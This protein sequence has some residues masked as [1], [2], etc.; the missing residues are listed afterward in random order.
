M[1]SHDYTIHVHTTKALFSQLFFSIPWARICLVRWARSHITVLI[2]NINNKYVWVVFHLLNSPFKKQLKILMCL[3]LPFFV[4][5][6]RI[7]FNCPDT[8]LQMT[9]WLLAKPMRGIYWKT[10]INLTFLSH[11][12]IERYRL[13]EYFYILIK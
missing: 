12:L 1:R 11:L 7:L 9:W 10:E 2:S 4:D 3:I 6:L 5:L 8:I 13:I